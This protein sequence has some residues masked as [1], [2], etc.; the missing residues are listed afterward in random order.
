[1]RA[2]NS[3]PPSVTGLRGP[4]LV[5]AGAARSGTTLLAGRLARHPGIVAPSI[6][7]PN[8]FSSRL[9]RGHGWYAGLFPSTSGLWMDASAQYTFPRYLD[10]LDRAAALAPQLKLVYIA[11]DPIPRAYSHYC[12]EVLYMGRYRNASFG[13]ALHE[14]P[15]YTGASDYRTI[16]DRIANAVPAAQRLVLP[17]DFLTDD[18]DAATAMVW[19][20]AGLDP[21]QALEGHADALYAN[22]SAV[23]GNPVARR[24]FNAVRGTR[25]YPRLRKVVGAER[26]RAARARLTTTESIPSLQEALATCSPADLAVLDA[27]RVR[28]AAALREYLGTQDARF[29][30][31]L[32]TSCGWLE[33]AA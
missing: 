9:E 15:D 21:A 16:L 12:H 17:F 14:S 4:D 18:L 13:Q 1:M 26:M 29:G 30:T 20:F 32:L 28:S 24:A 10:A 3:P 31:D 11:R 22:Q 7:E 33:G 2:Q 6:K 5:L 8:Y 27:L 19:R 25:L 23:I